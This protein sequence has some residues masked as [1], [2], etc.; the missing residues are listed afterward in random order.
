MCNL[1]PETK[2]TPD[3]W[4][5]GTVFLQIRSPLADV[6]NTSFGTPWLLYNRILKGGGMVIPLIFLNLP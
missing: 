5:I 6:D 2:Q 1:Y 3:N 4:Q